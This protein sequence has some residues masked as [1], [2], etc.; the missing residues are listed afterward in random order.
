MKEHGQTG[1]L[2]AQSLRALP[3]SCQNKADPYVKEKPRAC[4]PEESGKGDERLNH[5][6]Y[7]LGLGPGKKEIQG[8][9]EP[10]PPH[11]PAQSGEE[12]HPRDHIQA[13]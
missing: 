7:S 11:A 2:L 8:S 3:A 10:R 6:K 9:L 4:R 13:P 1:L 5:T 12:W